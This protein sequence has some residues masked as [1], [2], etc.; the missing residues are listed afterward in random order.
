M[1]LPPPPPPSPPPPPPPPPPL[2][3]LPPPP[4]LPPADGQIAEEPPAAPIGT[5][6]AAP[7]LENSHSHGCPA[8]MQT[9]TD[10]AL[11]DDPSTDCTRRHIF[12]NGVHACFDHVRVQQGRYS[13]VNLHE[14][15]EEELLARALALIR[16]GDVF[17]D[18]GAAVGYYALLVASTVLSV[19]VSLSLS[20]S[21]SLSLSLLS[22]SLSHPTTSADTLAWSLHQLDH[23]A[24]V[25]CRGAVPASTPS[26]WSLASILQNGFENRWHTISESISAAKLALPAARCAPLALAP[27]PLIFPYTYEKSLCGTGDLY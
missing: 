25:L 13:H 11:S 19:S 22:L 18:V 1:P 21:V 7:A 16:P 8:G 15:S 9:A 24:L 5:T 26:R 6:A 17:V 20:L 12:A 4:P 14:P 10:P 23:S 2:T 27:L 3:S